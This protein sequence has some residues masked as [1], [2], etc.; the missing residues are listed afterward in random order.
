MKPFFSLFPFSPRWHRHLPRKAKPNSLHLQKG[1]LRA[2]KF[3]RRLCFRGTLAA[4]S[5]RGRC[6]LSLL[7][8][9]HQARQ[10]YSVRAR[11]R[12]NGG[13]MRCVEMWLP[14]VR[15]RSFPVFLIRCSASFRSSN[16]MP[17][18]KQH[19]HCAACVV[20]CLLCRALC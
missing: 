4:P 7:S 8:S 14:A 20:L 2:G 1:V 17:H 13:K 6:S 11:R 15:V 9:H 5:R 3:P 18:P 12:E 10:Y 19:P 16:N